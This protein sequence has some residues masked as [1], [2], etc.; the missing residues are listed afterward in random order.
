MILL[1][2]FKGK[3]LFVRESS[4]EINHCLNIDTKPTKLQSFHN[5]S[6]FAVRI[7]Q[8]QSI[9]VVCTWGKRLS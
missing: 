9:I 8:S 3:K 5:S 4:F 2:I 6:A 7:I 1:L